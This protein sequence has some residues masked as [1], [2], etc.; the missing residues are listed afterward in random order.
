MYSVY[1]SFVSIAI[2]LD[3]L[4]PTETNCDQ[5]GLQPVETCMQLMTTNDNQL[6]M[7]QLSVA[8]IGS[9]NQ[10]VPVQFQPNWEKNWTWLDFQTTRL[11]A[12]H[13]LLIWTFYLS[14]LSH[15]WWFPFF[16]LV[17]FCTATGWLSMQT[18]GIKS[19][20]IPPFGAV[21]LGP[22]EYGELP[23]GCYSL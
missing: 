1:T 13:L 18:G 5:V 3:W 19:Y 8:L 11:S 21:P 4:W 22:W 15:I 6:V 23:F 7:V 9:E 20:R 16:W 14:I 10:P 12:F 17:N 2:G